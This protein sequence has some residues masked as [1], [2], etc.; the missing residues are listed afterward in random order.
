MEPS[1]TILFNP[2][3]FRKYAQ[4]IAGL[5]FPDGLPYSR[6]VH[7]PPFHGERTELTNEPAEKGVL[8]EFFLSHIMDDSCVKGHADER[9]I[10]VAFVIRRHN[11]GTGRGHVFPAFHMK[12]EEAEENK[13][14]KSP[15]NFI[16][17]RTS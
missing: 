10:P 1:Q 7:S 2:G 12:P 14:K 4:R 3:A 11:D 9:R 16:S 17:H 6:A 15:Y 13:I 8:K 5:D